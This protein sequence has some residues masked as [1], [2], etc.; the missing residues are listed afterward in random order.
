MLTASKPGK[1]SKPSKSIVSRRVLRRAEK[2][3]LSTLAEFV[4]PATMSEPNVTEFIGGI[5]DGVA[6]DMP[7]HE[8]VRLQSMCLRLALSCNRALDE[9]A[10]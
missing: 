4:D 7:K 10:E 8:L 6:R 5:V 9:R 3:P 1:P 2:K